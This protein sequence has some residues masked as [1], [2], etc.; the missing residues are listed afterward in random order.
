MVIGGN[1]ALPDAGPGLDPLVACVEARAELIVAEHPVGEVGAAADQPGA[2]HGYSAALFGSG[3]VESWRR[4][5][6]SMILGLI[7]W[8][9]M[10]KATP[11]ALAKPL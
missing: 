11:M 2:A 1:V 4:D 9:T 7:P 10:S 3:R 8:L 6:S 5:S